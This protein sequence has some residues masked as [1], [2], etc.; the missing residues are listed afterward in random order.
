MKRWPLRWKIA[1]YAAALGVLATVAG[2]ATTWT[3][4]RYA[5]IAALDRQLIADG[6]ELLRNVGELRTAGATASGGVD[7]KF[8][9][10]AWRDR[11]VE[12]SGPGGEVLYVSPNLSGPLL[13]D[14]NDA[15]HTREINGRTIRIATLR[16]NGVTLR[17]G[18]DL[19][20]VHQIGRD[21]IFGMFGAIPTVLVVVT[22]GGRWI[23]RRA[24]GPVEAISE[25]AARITAKRLDQ[26]L[27]LPP[28]NDE[29]AEL[30]N[31]LNA[32]FER[33]QR[34]FEQ[35]VRFS[36]D[37]SHQLKTPLTVLRAGI[38]EILT[39]PETRPK[40]QARADALLHQIHGLTSVA[41]DLLL[42][43]KADAGRLELR[44][45]K[46]DLRELLDGLVDDARALGERQ[47]LTIEA[48]LPT[49]LP[50]VADR[51]SIALVAQ[52]LLENAI[53]YNEPRGC[54][55]I[56]ARSAEAGV[57]LLIKNNGEPIPA[58]RAALIFE[59]FYR[60][61][62]DER[63]GGQ[64]LGLSIARELALAHGGE[65]TLVRSDPEWTEFRLWLPNGDVAHR[66][67][68]AQTI[69]ASLR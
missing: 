35:S 29:I 37:A 30:I 65:L 69:T 15:L 60:A 26:R 51:A 57:E 7:D 40:T 68:R 38:E 34:S 12:L 64:G 63:T 13:A 53:K 62:G 5:E 4:M 36:A 10:L 56:S 49:H 66:D 6:R 17:I 2:A 33:L 42:L 8:I 21:I 24:L 32:T 25:A 50:L 22:L 55:C 16:E 9:P 52:N 28:A 48:D 58:G 47:R 19:T 27:P 14:N 46:F 61:R 39:D 18:A 20:D 31:V 3:L 44:P 45:E 59:R 1:L 41:K 11:M 43:A 67:E 54:V 23:A